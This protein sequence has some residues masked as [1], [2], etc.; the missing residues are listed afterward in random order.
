M[1]YIR[2]L[3]AFRN[4]QLMHQ[5]PASA[6]ATW[7]A[8]MS[9]NNATGWKHTFNAAN[10]TVQALAGLS[11]QGLANARERLVAHR[12]IDYQKGKRGSAPL[13]HIVSLASQD[14]KDKYSMINESFGDAHASST[15]LNEVLSIDQSRDELDPHD[16][17]L[18]LSADQTVDEKLTIPKH[19]QKQKSSSSREVTG[20]HPLIMYEQNFGKLRPIV[21]DSLMTW[22]EELG[23]EMVMEGIKYAVIRGGKT[24][25]YLE[26]ILNYWSTAKLTSV[27]EVKD[28]ETLKAAK[29]AQSSYFQTSIKRETPTLFDELR[30]EGSIS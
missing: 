1:N 30:R 16:L 7:H 26:K 10:S 5:L 4:F 21:K 23:Y 8:L 6:V 18:D 12:L 17:S 24:F 2:E 14:F 22:C 27:D 13:Y 19:K 3:N 15:E 11:K 29:R 25:S 20:H 9:I 28:Y